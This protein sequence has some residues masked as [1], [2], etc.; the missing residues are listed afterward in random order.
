MS[1]WE[2]QGFG[3]EDLQKWNCF[4]TEMKKFEEEEAVEEIRSQ[5]LEM[6]ILSYMLDIQ[7]EISNR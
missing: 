6:L 7:T 3:P 1:Q 5:I 2:I 4:F